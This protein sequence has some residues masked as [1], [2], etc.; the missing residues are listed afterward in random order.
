MP[1]EKSAGSH[2]S[3]WHPAWGLHGKGRDVAPFAGVQP[4]DVIR[5]E[6]LLTLTLFMA[7]LGLGWL[8][9]KIN[10]GGLARRI[11]GNR[12][13]R[14]VEVAALSPSDRAM[15]LAVDGREFLILRC[16]GE[17]P[18]MTAL[19]EGGM[20]PPALPDAAKAEGVA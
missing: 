11:A 8:V 17:A 10:R 19:P 20:A 9:V 16:R 6:Q 7:V 15:I 2:L 18:L 1:E 14:L 12:R 4:L 3:G 13:M 5:P